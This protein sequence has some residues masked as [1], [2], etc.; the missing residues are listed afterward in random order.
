M[1]KKESAAGIT[2]HGVGRPKQVA[3]A[4][5]KL[6]FKFYLTEIDKPFFLIVLVLLVFGLI[7]MFSASYATSL[8]ESNNPY[9]YLKTQLVAAV[10]GT[11]IMFL[12]S[13]LDYHFFQN[14]K[15]VF[16]SYIIIEFLSLFTAF[17]GKSTADASRWI[18]IGPISFQPSE[19]L[20]I[21]FIMIF[22]YLL[23]LNFP[24][25]KSMKYSIAPFATILIATCG[26]LVLQRHLSAVLLVLVIGIAMMFVGDVPKK[27]M[28]MFLCAGL[29]L[30]VLFVL[31]MLLSGSDKFSYLTTRFQS[32]R[33]PTSD[34]S[35]DTAQTYQ[36]LLAIGSGGWFGL[37]FGNS[38]QK[39]LYLPES[40]N[41]FI[42]SIICE[43]LGFLGAL[44]V[45]LLFLL[46]VI[47]GFYI[48]V[49]AKDRF[50]MLMAV[51]IVLQIGVQAFLNI[52][53]SCNAF[54]NTGIA[55]PFFS[56][57]GTAL[58][59]Q[60]AEMGILLNISRQRARK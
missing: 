46:F 11:A 44:A 2:V 3:Q 59:L 41:D 39:Y 47:R 27:H 52:A 34:I 28:A 18:S 31:F 57:G 13:V 56:S 9:A 20:K 26:A 48:A 12:T 6:N 4:R 14:T 37:G 30:V 49:N 36:G 40:Q 7:M 23:A 5:N 24:K 55:L 15:V 8:Y 17:F 16:F 38:R 32:W 54:P 33:D 29:I 35:G 25:F 21:S 53:V 22:A 51:G 1:A 60:L 45:I 58:V 19:L 42:F 43:E 10:I 50:G